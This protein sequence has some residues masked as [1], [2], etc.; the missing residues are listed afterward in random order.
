MSAGLNTHTTHKIIDRFEKLSLGADGMFGNP[1]H[2][3]SRIAKISGHLLITLHVAINLRNPCDI[4]TIRNA[5]ALAAAM[6][7]AAVYKHND[8]LAGKDEIGISEK[9]PTV[10]NFVSVS[11]EIA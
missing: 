3:P 1:N 10:A 9:A 6:P 5:F 7:E 4:I 8:S 11:G 2:S